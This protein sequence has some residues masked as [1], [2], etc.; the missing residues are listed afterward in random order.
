VTSFATP[1]SSFIREGRTTPR[2]MC[3]QVG[4]TDQRLEKL[5][6]F[7]YLA[8]WQSLCSSISR[9]LTSHGHIY[10]PV[11][12]PR[13]DLSSSL[14]TSA[15]LFPTVSMTFASSAGD[16]LSLFVHALTWLGLFISIFD[17]SAGTGLV[18]VIGGSLRPKLERTGQRLAQETLTA[19][20]GLRSLLPLVCS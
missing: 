18:K 6:G 3:F 12:Y 9:W 7:H 17:R 14:R 11:D 19:H 5:C 20:L 8:G 10:S 13:L 4:R 16:M 1:L 2:L 15:A